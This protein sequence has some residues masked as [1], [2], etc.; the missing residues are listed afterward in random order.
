MITT[1]EVQG[2]IRYLDSNIIDS[3][4]IIKLSFKFEITTTSIPLF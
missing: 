4:T 2:V 3:L 1:I